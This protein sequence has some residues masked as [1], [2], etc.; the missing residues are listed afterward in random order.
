MSSH[1]ETELK[2]TDH[3]AA[4]LQEMPD[5]VRP[6]IRSIHNHTAPRTRYEYLKDIQKFLAYLSEK[7]GNEPALPDLSKLK[8]EDF[9][10]YLEYLEHYEDNG[11]ERTN[12]RVSLKRKLSALRCFFAYLFENGQIPSD[13]IRKVA[14]PKTHKKEI[15]RLENTE[16]AD[17]LSAVKHGRK[18]T[19]KQKDY[20]K[21]QALRDETIIRLLLTTGMRIS[22]CAE[23]DINDIDLINCRAHIVRKGG[24]ETVVYF[25]DETGQ[26]LAQY[27]ISRKKAKCPEEEKA[28]FLSSRNKR[29]SVRALEYMVK[30]YAARSVPLKKITPH[31][32]RA[33]YATE[34]YNATGDIYLVA[35]TLGHNDVKTTKD[36]YANL[37]ENRKEN[38][39]NLVSY[40]KTTDKTYTEKPSC[41]PTEKKKE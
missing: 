19:D 28:L 5:Y 18:L 29:M 20:H 8:K 13:E 40:S 24:T 15:I 25:P 35:E 9:E 7:T 37:S 30:K 27:L 31:K 6:Y 39:R 1:K 11:T 21:L 2:Y 36:H 41:L 22:E 34:L 16:A 3:T 10:E 32:L 23:L 33:T 4:L 12:S 17:L 14:M 38:A 26:I